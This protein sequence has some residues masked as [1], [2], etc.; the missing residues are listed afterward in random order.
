MQFYIMLSIIIALPIFFAWLGAHTDNGGEGFFVGIILSVTVLLL[1]F[2]ITDKPTGNYSLPIKDL[3]VERGEF[4]A[5]IHV[6]GVDGKVTNS[7]RIT[8]AA[9]LDAFNKGYWEI[10]KPEKQN[11]WIKSYYSGPEFIVVKPEKP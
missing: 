6:K 5:M 2:V 11:W 10:R 7:L 8:D 3:I 4:S 9:Q 1:A